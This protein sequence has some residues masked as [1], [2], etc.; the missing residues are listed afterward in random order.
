MVQAELMSGT[1]DALGEKRDISGENTLIFTEFIGKVEVDQGVDGIYMAAAIR[2]GVRTSKIEV[3]WVRDEK[4]IITKR[5]T[6]TGR[7]KVIAWLSNSLISHLYRDPEYTERKE[8]I[9]ALA[10][11]ID[12][13]YRDLEE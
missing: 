10:R 3:N 2:H 13:M 6:A 7:Q 11:E 4:S 1:Y 5:Q 8:E 12:S 9:I